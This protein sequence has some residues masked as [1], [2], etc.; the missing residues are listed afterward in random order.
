[1]FNL[2]PVPFLDGQLD[3]QVCP[4]NNKRSVYS[5]FLP[6]NGIDSLVLIEI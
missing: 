2:N 6:I 5:L 3:V 4:R 1:M